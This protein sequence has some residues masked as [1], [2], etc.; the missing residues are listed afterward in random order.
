MAGRRRNQIKLYVPD[1]IEARMDRLM[2]TLQRVGKSL[3]GE[4]RPAIE[5]LM[6]EYGILHSEGRE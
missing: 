2:E 3:S 5:K 6:E 4:L 1:S